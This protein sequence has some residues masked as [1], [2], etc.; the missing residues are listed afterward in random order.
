M[1]QS[2]SHRDCEHFKGGEMTCSLTEARMLLAVL[3]AS[4]LRPVEQL[5]MV[6][7]SPSSVS[8]LCSGAGIPPVHTHIYIHKDLV[9][10]FP[11]QKK[12]H[13][14]HTEICACLRKS[15]FQINTHL[16]QPLPT[17]H[18]QVTERSHSGC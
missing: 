7:R 6:S 12:G 16:I 18:W 13:I 3:S 15:T 11:W 2:M 5:W 1:R 14:L 4:I 8:G 17:T 9:S 10:T